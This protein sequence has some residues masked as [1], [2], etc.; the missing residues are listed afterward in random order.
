[1][2]YTEAV[3]RFLEKI[4]LIFNL[5]PKRREPGDGSDGYCDCIGLIIGA[6]R[7]MG[8]KWTGI[9]GSNWAARKEIVNLRKIGS[10]SDLEVGDIVLK[11]RLPGTSKYD[12][13]SRYRKGGK[14]YDGDLIDYYHAGVVY[15]KSPFQIRHMASKMTI[16]TAL[17]HNKN[18][19]W[20]YYGKSRQLVEASG[21]VIPTPTPTPQPVPATGTQAVLVAPSGST[22]NLRR[23]PS[24]R[25]ALIKQI[26]LGTIVDVVS[27]GEEWCAVKYGNLSGYMMAQFLDI[28][29]DGKGKY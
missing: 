20:N 6:I 16:D 17:N 22:V 1:M 21:G 5:N 23:T 28:V 2:T 13:P 26:P 3:K 24:K 10:I 14:Y 29:G 25:G 9:H 8:L 19:V 4:L 15:S 18:S 7:R 12:L 11:G 27:P